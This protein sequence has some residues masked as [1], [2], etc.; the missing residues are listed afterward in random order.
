MYKLIATDMDGT[1]LTSKSTVS[2][3]NEKAIIEAQKKGVKF[4]LASGRPVEG[5]K[6]YAKQLQMDKYEGYIIAFN[7][8]QIID[9][10]T[11]ETVYSEPLSKEDVKYIYNKAKEFGTTLVTYVNEYIYS[12]DL[13]EYSEIEIN[14]TGMKAIKINSIE[15]IIDKKIMKFMFVDEPKNINKYLEIMKKEVGNKYFIA[16]SNPHFLEIA[17]INASKGNSLKQL[18]KIL[19]IDI[20][21]TITCGDSYNDVDMLKL[22]CL[23]VAAKNAPDDIKKICKYVSR[24]NDEHIL[25][26][27][28]NKFIG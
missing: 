11:K 2:I 22:D 7:G 10:K 21:D 18:C 17:N 9:C 24:T 1:L 27:V 6:K 12:S 8:S 13:N 20:V 4:V 16:I 28:I 5:M 25:E 3:E 26:D 23:S 14:V 19:D 15:D